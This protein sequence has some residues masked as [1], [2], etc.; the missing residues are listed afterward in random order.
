MKW[1]TA[2]SGL[3]IGLCALIAIFAIVSSNQNAKLR[4]ENQRLQAELALAQQSA[5][6]QPP[7]A[8]ISSEVSGHSGDATAEVLKLRGELAALRRDLADT[9]KL[10][11][12]NL[13]LHQQIR[14]LT[15]SKSTTDATDEPKPLSEA[16]KAAKQFGVTKMNFMRD[17]FIAFQNYATQNQGQMP[18]NFEQARAY[19]PPEFNYTLDPNSFEIVCHGSLNQ[20]REKG[21]QAASQI[22]VLR[23]GLPTIGPNGKSYKAY[24]FAD[25]HCEIRLEPVEGFETWEKSH[26]IS[27]Q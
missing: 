22:I 1:N 18:S 15:E 27:T 25:G 19:L 12:Q 23:E 13:Q 6:Q 2:K 16:E 11:Q 20:I 21:L 17:W 10:A 7:S 4:A 8:E 14:A 24:G 3:G 26:I 9:A 5:V